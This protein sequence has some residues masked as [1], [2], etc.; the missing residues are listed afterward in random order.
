MGKTSPNSISE[1]SQAEC[2]KIPERVKRLVANL[3]GKVEQLG[4]QIEVLEQQHAE[5]KAENLLLKEQVKQNSR[6]SSKPQS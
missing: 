6:N 2:D 3:I 4:G 1:I 5:L